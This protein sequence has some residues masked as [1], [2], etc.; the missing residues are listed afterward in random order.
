MLISSW[1]EYTEAQAVALWET[2]AP[3]AHNA[4]TT[5]AEGPGNWVTF[6]PKK[7]KIIT[8]GDDD[9]IHLQA[10]VKEIFPFSSFEVVWVDI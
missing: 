8:K 9:L 1:W 2:L 6:A 4:N 10:L 7:M 3:F 5:T